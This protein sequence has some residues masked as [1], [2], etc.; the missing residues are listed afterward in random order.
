MNR[1]LAI[2]EYLKADVFLYYHENSVGEICFQK[3]WVMKVII[4]A[5][6]M[7]MVVLDIKGLGESYQT[8]LESHD[9]MNQE[10]GKKT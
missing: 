10:S 6:F 1:V 3:S 8:E 9:R 2:D 7:K 4:T 5:D